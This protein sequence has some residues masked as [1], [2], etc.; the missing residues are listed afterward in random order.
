M[1]LVAFAILFAA[2]AKA[3]DSEPSPA[4]TTAQPAAD[5]AEFRVGTDTAETVQSKLGKP[6]MIQRQ[7]NGSMMLIYSSTRTR[8][9]GTSFI[10]VVG[11]FAGGAKSKASTKIFFF[12]PDG[13][14]TNYT[15]SA[16]NADCNVSIA[17]SRCN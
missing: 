7:A 15:D 4:T 10:P 2:Q 5:P 16:A 9:K 1:L 8:V 12:G 11:L 13:R 3:D 17:G 14:L 6:F